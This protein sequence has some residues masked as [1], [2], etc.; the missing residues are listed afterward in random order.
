[1]QVF[2]ITEKETI[3]NTMEAMLSE[4]VKQLHSIIQAYVQVST[5]RMEMDGA[6]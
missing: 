4:K 1:M 5:P 3:N 2:C 6:I